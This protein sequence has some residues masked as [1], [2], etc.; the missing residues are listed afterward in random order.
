MRRTGEYGVGNKE[1]MENFKSY[2]GK[3]KL[4]A[5]DSIIWGIA[6][7]DPGCVDENCL[8]YDV[9]LVIEENENIGLD[10]REIPNGRYAIFE[11]P[12]TKEAVS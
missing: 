9:G 11:I 10:V 5:S 1:L 12:H 2:L 7:D 6:L 8:R 4:L 3:R